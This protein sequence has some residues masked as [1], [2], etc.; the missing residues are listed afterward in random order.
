[1]YDG[2]FIAGINTLGGQAT[3]HCDTPYW[4]TFEVM[5]LDK[6]P[7]W[8]GHTPEQAIERIATLARR[9]L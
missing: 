6:A 3:Y 5:E 8:D 2:M 4:D 7:E 1:M 9:E